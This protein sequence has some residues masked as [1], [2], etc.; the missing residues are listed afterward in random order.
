MLVSIIIPV[1]NE[2]RSLAT[3]LDYLRGLPRTSGQDIEIIVVD[4]GSHDASPHIAARNADIAV[5]SALGRAKQMNAG[6]KRA[7]GEM[8]VFLHADST[9]TIDLLEQCRKLTDANEVWGFSAVRLDDEAPAFRVIESFMNKRSAMS[10]IATGDQMI[11]VQTSTFKLLEGYANIPLMEDIE[12][13]KRLKKI[14]RP[15]F[16]RRPV[17][18]SARK[19]RKHGIVRTVVMM[20]WLRAAYFFGANPERLHAIYYA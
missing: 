6:A 15:V 17:I 7:T 14:S 1:L 16:F 9:P 12:L 2:E 20:W 19:W 11:C 13:S 4:G 10:G 3:L 8:L 18:C 5:C